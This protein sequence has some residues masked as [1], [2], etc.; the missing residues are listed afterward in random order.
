MVDKKVCGCQVG[1]HVLAEEVD[2]LLTSGAT[3]GE[4]RQILIEA[5]EA[6][7]PPYALSRHSTQCLGLSLRQPA[8]GR[9]TAPELPKVPE[10]KDVQDLALALFFQ[11]LKDRPA[12]V[13]TRE[14]VQVLLPRLRKKA[15]A[16]EPDS[17]DLDDILNSL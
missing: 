7:I 14:L 15:S 2:G 6:A 10:L 9:R 3:Y 11:R 13:S 17:D 4:I 12:E 1:K 8:P 16:E 5:N